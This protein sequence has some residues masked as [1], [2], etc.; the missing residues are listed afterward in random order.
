MGKSRHFTNPLNW[1]MRDDSTTIDNFENKIILLENPSYKSVVNH[2]VKMDAVVSM[3]CIKGHLE[4]TLNMKKFKAKAPC[5]FIVLADQILQCDYFSDDFS[6]LTIIM[7]KSFL[8]D[9]FGDIQV[10]MP[11]FRSVHDNPWIPL[12][13]E[14][15][16]S[17]LEYFFLLQRAVRRK[18]NPNLRETLKHLLLAFF[19][20]TGYRFHMVRDESQKSKQD[21]LVEKF[22]AIVKGNYR[23]Q[24]M[25]EFYSEKLFLTPKHL[26][27]VIKERSGKSAGEWIEDHVMLEAMA[28]LKSTDKTI[29]QISDEL[30]FPSQSFFG[31]Y[32]KRRAGISPKE[33]RKSS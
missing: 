20:G 10:S 11:L 6:G 24:R 32:F 31:K 4:G 21:I 8:E 7:S 1:N 13:Q 5:Q 12:N 26:S 25:I 16:K 33:Y 19:Y 18:E 27:G 30:N 9:S 14:E 17:M 3:I 29:L 2:P 15:L 28:L 22:L 23:E